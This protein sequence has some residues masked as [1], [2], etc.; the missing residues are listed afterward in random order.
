MLKPQ[1][2]GGANNFYGDDIP[3]MLDQICEGDGSERAAYILMDRITPM[4]HSNVSL[5]AGKEL[6]V[7]LCRAIEL[8]FAWSSFT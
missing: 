5:R 6:K 7:N 1:R 3:K 8:R 4:Q 2:E